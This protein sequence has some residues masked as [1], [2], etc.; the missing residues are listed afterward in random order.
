MFRKIDFHSEFVSWSRRVALVA[1]AERTITGQHNQTTLV[2]A[3]IPVLSY[4]YKLTKFT[5]ARNFEPWRHAVQLLKITKQNDN[6]MIVA[7][8]LGE[9]KK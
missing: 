3:L 9:R 2:I 4:D 1:L 8:A 6:Q 7:F 5:N